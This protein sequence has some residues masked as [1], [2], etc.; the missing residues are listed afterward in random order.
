LNSPLGKDKDKDK[1]GA[2]DIPMQQKLRALADYQKAL[3]D[4]HEAVAK[5][6]NAK[7]KPPEF[8]AYLP[9]E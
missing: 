6:P 5:N 9:T 7:V 1:K 3:A 8:K 4:Y 2:A